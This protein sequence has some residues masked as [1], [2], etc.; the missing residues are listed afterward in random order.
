[1]HISL[2]NVNPNASVKVTCDIRGMK[3]NAAT[4]QII[5]GEAISSCN[6]FEAPNSVVT[7]SFS[8]F[9][10]DGSLLTVDMPARSV[11]MLELK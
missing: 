1:M 10:L 7:K 5:T 2:V 11:V 9:R 4:G 8:A 3:M 6:T